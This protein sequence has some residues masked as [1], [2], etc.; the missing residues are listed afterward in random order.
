[1][2]APPDRLREDTARTTKHTT[3]HA[4]RRCRGADSSIVTEN[5]ASIG[6]R[7]KKGD[8][9]EKKLHGLVCDEVEQF[10]EVGRDV[11]GGHRRPPRPQTLLQWRFTSSCCFFSPS[12]EP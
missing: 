2:R 11:A 6:V 12:R 4:D 10:V 1:M 9:E 5:R 8:D 3:V 7:R